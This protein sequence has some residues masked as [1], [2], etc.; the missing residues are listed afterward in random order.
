MTDATI[1]KK[2]RY[3]ERANDVV[4]MLA[5]SGSQ[6]TL[7]AFESGIRGGDAEN[8][9]KLLRRNSITIRGFLRI[10]PELFVVRNGVVKLKTQAAESAPE[11]AP[12]PPAAP[13]PPPAALDIRALLQVELQKQRDAEAARMARARARVGFIRQAYPG[14]RAAP[15]QG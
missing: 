10:Y 15:F 8:L 3:Q 7:V 2:A 6:M 4:D 1:P 13:P 14:D 11:P 12:P 9:I 5:G